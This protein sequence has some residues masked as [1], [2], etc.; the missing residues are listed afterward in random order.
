MEIMEHGGGSPTLGNGDVSS[1]R[2]CESILLKY[3][4][5]VPCQ[6]VA[7]RALSLELGFNLAS[8]CARP[9]PPVS[10]AEYGGIHQHS[11][12][13]P[14]SSLW[15]ALWAGSFSLGIFECAPAFAGSVV[16]LVDMAS[17]CVRWSR[18]H[19]NGRGRG[20]PAALR[21]SRGPAFVQH[22]KRQPLKRLRSPQALMIPP[23]PRPGKQPKL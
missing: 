16:S 2:R 3:R 22:L 18:A 4:E 14:I 19:R 20:R 10:K 6:A 7:Q 11:T 21:P 5:A 8:A 15:A 12:N 1:G 9:E 13:A 23:Y 17:S